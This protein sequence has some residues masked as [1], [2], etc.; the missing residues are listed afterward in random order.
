V[1]RPPPFQLDVPD[2]VDFKVLKSF[3]E[4]YQTF[5]GFVL[6]R[7]YSVLLN[8]YQY[9]PAVQEEADYILRLVGNIRAHATASEVDLSLIYGPNGCD[10]PCDK[11]GGVRN[12]NPAS[13]KPFIGQNTPFPERFPASPSN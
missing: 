10:E 1:A 2:V 5:A 13:V 9:P 8:G 3:V 12:L 7:L 11:N 4:F 6:Y